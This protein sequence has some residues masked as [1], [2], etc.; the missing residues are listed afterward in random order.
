MLWPLGAAAAGIVVAALGTG[1]TFLVANAVGSGEGWTPVVVAVLGA[2][3]SVAVGVLV[4]LSLL[5]VAARRLFPRGRRLT[6]VL[7]SA[8]IILGAVVLGA[9]V[10]GGP[11]V[12]SLDAGT[13]SA[14]LLVLASLATAGA[15]ALVFWLCARD[16]HRPGPPPGWPLP[17]R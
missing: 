9:V 12:R 13:G 3:G 17:P 10:L 4:W 7:V 6:P 2:F 11:L 8:A 15:P 1:A 5:V 14:V 16:A